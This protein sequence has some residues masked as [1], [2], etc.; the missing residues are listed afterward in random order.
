MQN[1]LSGG[2]GVSSDF[3]IDKFNQQEV[4]KLLNKSNSYLLDLFL[5]ARQELINIVSDLEINDL[6]RIG[7]DPYLGKAPLRAIIKLTYR[8][9]E[10][11]LRD[12]RRRL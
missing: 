3:D 10:I 6:N 1:I 5:Q 9:L 12:A 11:H 2:E 4:E 8:H 7:N